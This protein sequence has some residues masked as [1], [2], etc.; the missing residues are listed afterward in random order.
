[1]WGSVKLKP[2]RLTDFCYFDICFIM[3]IIFCFIL[4][5]YVL[6]S[7]SIITSKVSEFVFNK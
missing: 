2:Y 1:M 3:F 7:K 5:Y 4:C 6:L